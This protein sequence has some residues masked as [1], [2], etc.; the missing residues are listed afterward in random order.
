M[1]R[2]MRVITGSEDGTAKIW[3]FDEKQVECEATLTS[4][5]SGMERWKGHQAGITSVSFSPPEATPM[6]LTSSKDRDIKVWTLDGRCKMTMPS[7]SEVTVKPDED[8]ASR[9]ARGTA[10]DKSHHE[11]GHDDY[12]N[13]AK[14][15]PHFFGKAPHILSCSDDGSAIIWDGATGRKLQTF[16]DKDLGHTGPVVMANWSADCNQVLTCSHDKTA[17]I[18]NP[19]TGDCRRQVPNSLTKSDVRHKGPVWSAHFSPD[20]HDILTASKDMTAKVW[21]ANTGQLKRTLDKQPESPYGHKDL[22]LGA[23]WNPEDPNQ[24]LTC[25]LDNTAKLW[26]LRDKSQVKTLDH[27]TSCVW[28]A[29][30]GKDTRII[31]TCSHDMTALVYDQRLMLPK[32]TLSGHTGILWQASFSADDQ[33]VLTCSEDRTAKVWNL[34]SGARRPPCHTLRDKVNKHSQAVMCAAFQE[35]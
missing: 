23:V 31:L 24:V 18:W 19:K 25:S 4:G 6:A 16:K 14:W 26:D 1:S 29:V 27:H 11:K 30:F 2:L 15:S 32:Q 33:W 5:S 9:R 10:S 34:A 7:V 35:T 22:V 8:E 28:T 13:S 17:M 12:V 3:H 20:Q 21:D